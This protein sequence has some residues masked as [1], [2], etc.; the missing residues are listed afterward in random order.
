M[1]MKPA[2]LL[3]LKLCFR[4]MRV[5]AIFFIQLERNLFLNFNFTFNHNY[6]LMS[7]LF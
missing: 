6:P 4:D 3:A 2:S 5:L 1:S 7:T